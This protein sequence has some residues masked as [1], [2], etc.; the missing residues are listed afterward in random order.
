MSHPFRRMAQ[1]RT[2]SGVPE[3]ARVRGLTTFQARRSGRKPAQKFA[4]ALLIM[5]LFAGNAAFAANRIERGVDNTDRRREIQVERIARSVF[6]LTVLAIQRRTH[7][8]GGEFYEVQLDAHNVAGAPKPIITTQVWVISG[9]TLRM[10]EA[11]LRAAAA[12]VRELVQE[13]ELRQSG[14]RPLLLRPDLLKSPA[15]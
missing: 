9:A 6:P 3:A 14:N 15:R 10:I 1:F 5:W 2:P 11:A 7:L 13:T 8:D 4:R 12:Q